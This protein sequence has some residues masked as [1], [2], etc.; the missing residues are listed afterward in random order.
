MTDEVPTGNAD[1]RAADESDRAARVSAR[2]RRRWKRWL[3]LVVGIVVLAPA[4]FFTFWTL[5][6]LN[7]TY[8]RGDRP[9]Y[10]QKF[11]QK[12]W[13][14]KTWEGELAMVNYPGSMQ[15]KWEFSVR[16]DSIAQVINKTMGSHVALTYEQ[17]K[18]V[19]TSCLGE[20][21]YFVTGVRVL[22]P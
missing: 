12:G 1:G 6:A 19:P 21:E 4:L 17:H 5:I 11:S 8:S 16:S 22:S 18:K 10:V 2:P 14:C 3:F 15:E 7:Y 20:T 9:G 13:L